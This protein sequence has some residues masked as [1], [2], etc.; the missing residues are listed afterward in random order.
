[1]NT[2]PAVLVVILGLD[3]RITAQ[4]FRKRESFGLRLERIGAIRLR[5]KASLTN[6]PAIGGS[7]RLAR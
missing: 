5:R 6:S 1:M 2:F 4:S 7:S 3:P